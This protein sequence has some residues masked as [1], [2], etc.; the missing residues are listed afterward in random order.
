M[1]D[2]GRPVWSLVNG[3]TQL[4]PYSLGELRQDA[5]YRVK[6]FQDLVEKVAYL[7]F[8]NPEYVLFFRGQDDDYRNSRGST[9]L[10]PSIFRS[11]SNYVKTS[12]FVKRF[13]R[14]QRA[15]KLLAQEY[16]FEGKRRIRV[17]DILRWAIL[18]HYEVCQTPLLDVTSSLRVAC[19]FAYSGARASKP[20][21]YIL[22]LPQI[23]GSVTASSET[24][25]QIIRLL[26]ICPPTALRPHYQEGYLIGEYPTISLEA[27]AEY[28]RMELDFSRRLIAKFRLPPPDKFWS[29]DFRP[30]PRAALYPKKDKLQSLAER[31]R[32][33][34][35]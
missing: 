34:V 15:E 19:S 8:R 20:M 11:R 18:Q 5:G 13:D 31:I 14:L 35:G 25:I 16:S 33:Q 2:F 22:G 17:H 23:S 24:G 10:Y 9:I 27:K 4:K 29:K 12:D 3:Q 1:R 21:V 32:G 30:I 26:S 6:H 28:R 7:S